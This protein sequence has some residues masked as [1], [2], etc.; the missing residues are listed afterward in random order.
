MP[1]ESRTAFGD[2]WAS[3]ARLVGE[4]QIE[5]ARQGLLKLLPA[6]VF[7]G[8]S[9]LDIGCGSGLHALA[10]ARLGVRHV[11]AIDLDQNS[12][13]TT[14]ALLARHAGTV[15]WTVRR[16]DVFDLQPR[17][18]G[19]YDIVYS[20]GVL[21][22]TGDVTE[23]LGKAAALV[24]PGGHFAFALYRPTRLDRL[25]VAEKRWY[26]KAGP[27]SQRLARAIH[28]GLLRVRLALTGRTLKTYHRR[29]IRRAAWTS[30]TMSTIG[31]G[32][33]LPDHRRRRGRRSDDA[34][35][36]REGS[37]ARHQPVGDP[38]WRVRLRLRRVRLPPPG[39]RRPP[40]VPV[41]T[42]NFAKLRCHGPAAG[43]TLLLAA[44]CAIQPLT[45]GRRGIAFIT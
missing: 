32:L 21:H 13:A 2:N 29:P 40:Y 36:P 20:W 26:A 11:L 3:Y 9:F 4:P 17:Q 12:V 38:A 45:S 15:P 27:G 10:A 35:G 1:A 39:L 41:D 14:E 8:R 18:H 25:W 44:N 16:A 43:S 30:A 33:P 7:E 28:V 34:A 19:R 37:G 31:S 23:A 6:A 42:A 22:H 5:E 24:A